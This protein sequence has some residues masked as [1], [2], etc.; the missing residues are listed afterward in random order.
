MAF[1]GSRAIREVPDVRCRS[2]IPYPD[3]SAYPRLVSELVGRGA[4]LQLLSASLNELPNAGATF[5][6]L[7]GEPGIGKSRL[8]A[9]LV[10][11]ADRRGYLALSGCGS[12][13]ER[14]LPFSV[15]TD[16]LD[17]YVASLGPD[18]LDRLGEAALAHLAPVLP[19]IAATRAA[20]PT[21]REERYHAYRAVRALL[22][23]LS[24]DK[25]LVVALDDAQWADEASVELIS[26]IVRKPPSSRVLVA[27]AMRPHPAH[28]RLVSALEAAGDRTRWI[29]LRPLSR[30][31]ADALFGAPLD[32]RSR[33]ALY[34]QSGGNPFYLLALQRGTSR[35]TVRRRSARD[36]DGV[37]PG[38]LAAIGEEIAA[39]RPESRA[40]LEAA[41][42]AGDPFEVDVAAAVAALPED[43]V[44]GPLDDALDAALVHATDVPRR[45][46][47]RHPIVWQ[48]I[49]ESAGDG[50]RL[51]AHRRAAASLAARGAP[52]PARAHHVE[53]SAA[54]G[55]DDAIAVLAEAASTVATH[56]P[57]SAAHWYE[58]ALRLL[59]EGA[60]ATGRRLPLLA[61]R[62]IA[63]V[64]T[65]RLDEARDAL[66][67]TL[68]LIPPGMP[69]LRV[70][71]TTF[72]S[73]VEHLL[74]RHEE[75]LARRDRALAE[76]GAA[77]STDLLALRMQGAVDALW[78]S[79]FAELGRWAAE[80]LELARELSDDVT[81]AMSLGFLAL[82]AYAA[83]DVPKAVRLVQEAAATLDRVSDDALAIRPDAAMQVAQPEF[84]MG[85]LAEAAAHFER[86]IAVARATGQGAR[87]HIMTT[88]LAWLKLHQG[89]LEEAAGL[90]EATVEVARLIAR[91][92]DLC[93]GL[94]IHAW[95]S[96]VRGDSDTA[97]AAA[98][99]SVELQ[100]GLE[101]S[102]LAAL[103]AA[104]VAA[105]FVELGEH[106]RGADV[107]LEHAGGRALDRL[108]AGLRCFYYEVLTRAD[109]ADGR[110][111]DADAWARR[112][113][114]IADRLGLPH[115]KT[116][117]RLAEAQV[118]LARGDADRAVEE[119][120]AAV[121]AAEAVGTT[122]SGARARVVAGRA[123]AMA[124][125]IGQ[126][127]DE[128][129]RAARYLAECGAARMEAEAVAEL[130]RLGRRVPR[131]R[132]DGHVTGPAGLSPR[133]TQIAELVSR[134]K[135]NKEIAAELFL[136][137]RTV[138]T[139]VSNIFVKLGVSSRAAVAA[140]IASGGM[141]GRS[142]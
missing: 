119:A 34:A 58:T 89:R 108:P 98:R 55:D 44:L 61:S 64:A 106:R 37:P 91:P 117:G 25:P 77:G 82:S 62:A 32:T 96:A 63:L 115:N 28:P 66:V 67:E 122:I 38:V 52:A 26:Y 84:A 33:D 43:A 110:V 111:D 74:G 78:Q 18:A 12:E 128:L 54:P 132:P 101:R 75:A 141:G 40:F 79:D 42:V 83:E 80:A 103:A 22:E 24:Y 46:R 29:E 142:E 139:H 124:G 65:G 69:S 51:A 10:A 102:Y 23:E 2:G 121:R 129:G 137:D 133:E 70:Q 118:A 123:Y 15:V 131:R 27:L 7:V 21:L 14:D 125:R 138:E 95:V 104:M 3:A 86:G 45:F 8:V 114:D 17:A 47:F 30:T 50:W 59:P 20:P 49:Y 99:E 71:L 116:S 5:V 140:A 39:L 107:L 127:A 56:A 73:A 19:A 90:A 120:L 31:E 100:S 13:L 41:A 60:E 93:L 94:A 4:E 130:R 126:A 6:A 81:A 35:R 113:A 92:Q 76:V 57:A 48:A 105:A 53:R 87:L 11:D 68:A 97:S 134:G 85:R 9:E 72:C 135:T 109:L 16:A 1:A 36:A 88:I 136:S 112:G